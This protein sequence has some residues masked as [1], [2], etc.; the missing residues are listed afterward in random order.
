M[1][2]SSRR[3]RKGG[4]ATAR[5][6]VVLL[7]ALDD[8]GDTITVDGIASRLGVDAEQARRLMRLLVAASASEDVFL[9]ISVSDDESEIELQFAG[10][11]R[12]HRVRL[13]RSETLALDAALER[14][15]IGAD[16]AVRS[17]LADSFSCR[18][19]SAEEVRRMVAA[20]GSPEQ[21]AN[22]EA[23]SSALLD[24]LAVEFPYQASGD[25]APRSRRVEP[26]G[27]RAEGDDWYLDAFDLDRQAE[28][29]FRLDRMGEVRQ[30]GRASG[31][32]VPSAATGTTGHGRE[33]SVVFHDPV[34]LDV[35]EWWHLRVT[36]RDGDAVEATLPWLGGQW[37]VR[38][39]AACGGSVEVRDA[40]LAAAVR[41]YARSWLPRHMRM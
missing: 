37:L 8:E 16:D 26:M 4:D 14:A 38:H 22:L 32:R 23:C 5:Q 9:P 20:T 25:E 6:L 30:A 39:L 41:D 10:G 15:G 24:G 36:R 40:E 31:R 1:A 34:M 13:T 3:G 27:I 33:V 11:V 12:G 28:R 18:D 19:R 17:T 7:S 35:F 2:T 29:T 21:A